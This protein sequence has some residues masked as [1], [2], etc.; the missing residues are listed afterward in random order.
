MPGTAEMIQFINR[1]EDMHVKLYVH[2]VNAIKTEQPE[3]W[4]DKF[5]DRII[6][7][8]VDAIDLEYEWGKN[9]IGDG[10]LGL[11]APDLKEYLEFV[12]NIRLESVGLPKLYN[13]KNPFLG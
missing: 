8:V 6:N 3:L 10:I 13:A 4:T 2:V 12:G 11:T 5:K 1:D 7:N 9:C